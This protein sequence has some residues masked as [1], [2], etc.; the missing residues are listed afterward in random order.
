MAA[1]TAAIAPVERIRLKATRSVETGVATAV[2]FG[3]P[4]GIIETV[5]WLGGKVFVEKFLTHS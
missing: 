5:N 2:I 3:T 1:T 4:F